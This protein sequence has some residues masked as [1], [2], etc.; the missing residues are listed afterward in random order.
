VHRE[1]DN[2]ERV[3]SLATRTATG[4]SEGGITS[5]KLSLAPGLDGL[6]PLLTPAEVAALLRTSRKA[7]YC[8]IERG[9][10]PGVVRL[11]RRVLVRRDVLLRSL[12][13]NRSAV[14]GK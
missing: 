13:E 5:A 12:D 14:A 11:G 9:Q 1:G 7:V 4:A 8:M 6:P 10:I 2:V 3:P